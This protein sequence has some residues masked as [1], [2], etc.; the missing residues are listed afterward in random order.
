MSGK[1]YT[2]NKTTE[3]SGDPN[4]ATNKY[5]DVTGTTVELQRG[6]NTYD[7]GYE[8]LNSPDGSV[9]IDTE[10][11]TALLDSIYAALK[12]TNFHLSIL[13]GEKYK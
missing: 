8:K 4:D 10:E 3:L 9:K 1:I 11:T 6:L 13:T 7:L 2:P 5:A 12:E